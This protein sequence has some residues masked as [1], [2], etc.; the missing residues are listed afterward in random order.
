MGVVTGAGGD[1]SV[2]GGLLQS[3]PVLSF[4]LSLLAGF[5]L[6]AVTVVGS[7]SWCWMLNPGTDQ[8]AL[9][10]M[11]GGTKGLSP[12][13]GTARRT[14]PLSQCDTAEPHNVSVE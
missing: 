1:W 4:P 6:D 9:G 13:I 7:W 12:H 2:R 10:V 14:R 3:H 11:K 5:F 8:L